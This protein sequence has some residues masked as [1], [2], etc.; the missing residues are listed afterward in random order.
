M[1][2]WMAGLFLAKSFVSDWSKTAGLPADLPYG[3]PQIVVMAV[4]TILLLGYIKLAKVGSITQIGLR[5][6]GISAD[7]KTFAKWA[8]LLTV[9]YIALGTISWLVLPWFIENPSHVFKGFLFKRYDIGTALAV[10]VAFPILEE[11]WFR[12][13]L[14]TGV[15]TDLGRN[16]AIVMSAFIFAFA[17]GSA[18]P[19]NQFLGGLVF[20]WAFEQRRGLIAPILLHMAGNGALFGL[21]VL[22]VKL[23]Y[24]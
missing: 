4:F 1:L 19:A 23:G 6:E 5:S 8:A 22:A 16:W 11:I 20:A 3:T 24:V 10:I 21:S 14:Y 12:G 17:H 13:L 9:F 7:L 18:I 15:R 2:A